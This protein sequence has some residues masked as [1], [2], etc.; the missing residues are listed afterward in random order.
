M[1]PA[2]V[3]PLSV[4]TGFLGAGKSTLLNHMLRDPRYADTAVLV[5]E[6]GEVPI[7]HALVRQS[8]ENVVVLSGGCICCRVAGDLVRALRELHF[9][10]VEGAIP[11]FARAVVET[12]GLADPAP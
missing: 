1:S 12:T 11:P 6:W 9:Q 2:P 4:L 3:T 8:S 7:D 5:N 10:R